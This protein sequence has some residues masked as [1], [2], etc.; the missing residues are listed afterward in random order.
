MKSRAGAR[1]GR[2]IYRYS[3]SS[4]A[5]R[6]G[7]AGCD[8]RQLAGQ[9]SDVADGRPEAAL[10]IGQLH[11]EVGDR[12]AQRVNALVGDAPVLRGIALQPLVLR[13]DAADLPLLQFV[14]S[15]PRAR[16]SATTAPPRRGCREPRGGTGEQ[17]RNG[18]GPA[19]EEDQQ[20]QQWRDTERRAQLGPHLRPSS[21]TWAQ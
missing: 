9:P 11:F 20:P 10:L 1:I 2:W 7:V 14:W 6:D 21:S 19:D 3:R 12:L 15:V 4:S 13:V 18:G 16:A 8:V 17:Q 5:L